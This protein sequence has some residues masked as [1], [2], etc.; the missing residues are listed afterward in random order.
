VKSTDF[1]EYSIDCF[2]L[3][4]TIYAVFFRAEVQIWV[5]EHE[6]L[7]FFYGKLSLF[8]IHSCKSWFEDLG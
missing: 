5:F 4:Q 8:A 6:T 1:T 7:S 3:N 2:H